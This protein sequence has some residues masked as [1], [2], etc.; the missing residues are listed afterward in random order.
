MTHAFAANIALAVN[1]T[2]G[3]SIDVTHTLAANVALAVACRSSS[4]CL[5]K[6]VNVTHAFAASVAEAVLVLI[7]TCER[8]NFFLLVLA[9]GSAFSKDKGT[10]LGALELLFTGNAASS[11]LDDNLNLGMAGGVICAVIAVDGLFGYRAA[12]LALFTLFCA[13][14]VSAVC[15]SCVKSSTVLLFFTV[16]RGVNGNNLAAAIDISA[17]GTLLARLIALCYAGGGNLGYFLIVMSYHIGFGKLFCITTRAYMS[18]GLALLGAGRSYGYEGV[19]LNEGIF[20]VIKLVVERGY[21]VVYILVTERAVI[22]LGDTLFGTG[23]GDRFK[24]SVLG[25]LRLFAYLVIERGNNSSLI[26]GVLNEADR[27]VLTAGGA[28]AGTGCGNLCIIYPI[29][30]ERRNFFAAVDYFTAVHAL[31]LGGVARFGAGGAY[32][33]SE[34][35]IALGVYTVIIGIS[36]PLLLLLNYLVTVIT[37]NLCSQLS[38]GTVTRNS[39][40]GNGGVGVLAS[41]AVT[42]SGVTCSATVAGIAGAAASAVSAAVVVVISAGCK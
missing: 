1:S 14:A 18:L 33:G 42:A 27:A 16:S 13:N 39:G 38:V 8:G 41:S 3:K 11:L 35:V 19:V 34:G 2:C 23:S 5:G 31:N 40:L 30:S 4:L 28:G 20:S 9:L 6:S 32:S 21:V 17:H 22:F 7:N 15:V 25:E 12:I 24:S 36:I 37:G 29:V 10:A 26:L